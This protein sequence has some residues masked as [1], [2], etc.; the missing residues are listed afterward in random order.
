MCTILKAMESVLGIPFESPEREV[1]SFLALSLLSFE[2]RNK[3]LKNF[4]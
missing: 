3:M 2:H 4:P 1:S